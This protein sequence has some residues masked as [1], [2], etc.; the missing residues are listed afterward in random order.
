MPK[1]LIGK[2]ILLCLDM[3]RLVIFLAFVQGVTSEVLRRQ[4]AVGSLHLNRENFVFSFQAIGF[5]C[6]NDVF[7]KDGVSAM[8]IFA[9]LTYH[10]YHNGLT[11]AKHM[12]SLYDKYGEFVSNNGK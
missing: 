11:L 5:M 4:H 12:Q 7:D 8:S 3:K 2:G 10:V 9:E 6:G 1:S